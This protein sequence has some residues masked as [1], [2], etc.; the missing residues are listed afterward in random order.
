MF[1]LDDA[2]IIAAAVQAAEAA[3]AA[4]A[5]T[6]AATAGAS[7]AAGTE[8]GMGITAAHGVDAASL[9]AQEATANAA[10]AQQ[11]AAQAAQAGSQAS[12]ASAA[13]PSTGAEMAS[14]SVNPSTAITDQMANVANGAQ[15]SLT[16]QSVQPAVNQAATQSATQPAVTQAT[17]NMAE[18]PVYD[19][20][21]PPAV[22]PVTAGAD[23]GAAPGTAPPT[24]IADKMGEWA[25]KAGET[26]TSKE[27]LAP[28]ALNAL[29]SALSS[30]GYDDVSGNVDSTLQ[31]SKGEVGRETD[32]SNDAINSYGKNYLSPEAIQRNQDEA[33]AKLASD[34]VENQDR[35]QKDLG[36]VVGNTPGEYSK[37]MA[38]AAINS[39][40]EAADYARKLAK[41]QAPAF[42]DMNANIG[43]MVAGR[44]TSDAA[45]NMRNAGY[46]G[47]N[48]LGEVD[49]SKKQLAGAALSGLGSGLATKSLASLFGG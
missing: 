18:L 22:Q 37:A 36:G 11:A 20:A 49:G 12:A 3:A 27:F 4:E 19:V 35:A 47:M 44:E 32:R 39:S 21:T 34:Y 30:S 2:A 46:T 25:G 43:E 38:D 8:A 6:A 31:E 15:S 5:A 28:L 48:A 24:S 45:S 13:M 33:Y 29:G 9:A 10:A 23:A 42:A 41:A 26:L 40:S 1:V 14:A 16:P 17:T 7:A